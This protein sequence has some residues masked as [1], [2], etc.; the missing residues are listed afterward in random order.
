VK[1]CL[2]HIAYNNNN[3]VYY[4]KLSTVVWRTV[5]RMSESAAYA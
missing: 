5:F 1:K 2:R 4:L 3:K